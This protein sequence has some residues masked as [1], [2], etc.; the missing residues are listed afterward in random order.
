VAV[1]GNPAGPTVYQYIT[2]EQNMEYN[3]E[4]NWG[5]EIL[6]CCLSVT[7]LPSISPLPPSSAYKQTDLFVPYN[8][9]GLGFPITSTS[10]SKILLHFHIITTNSVSHKIVY[11]V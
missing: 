11:F 1:I 3:W 10:H 9:M 4:A 5:T 7:D 8:K 6:R 2:E